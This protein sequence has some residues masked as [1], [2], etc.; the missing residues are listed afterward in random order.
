VLTAS[1]FDLDRQSIDMRGPSTLNLVNGVLPVGTTISTVG[2]SGDVALNINGRGLN[3]GLIKDESENLNISVGPSSTFD[4]YGTLDAGSS[5]FP[6]FLRLNSDAAD[7]VTNYGALLAEGVGNSPGGSF[8][9]AGGLFDNINGT[10]FASGG[11]ININSSIAFS[12]SGGIAAYNA[13]NG[14]GALDQFRGV[15]NITF[16]QS[17][18]PGSFV[19]SGTLSVGQAALLDIADAKF[20]SADSGTLVNSGLI[21]S[22]G[23]L[24]LDT[25]VQQFDSGQIGASAGG[26]IVVTRGVDGGIVQL[27]RDV[28]IRRNS[29]HA[30]LHRPA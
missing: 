1:N 21:T 12:N 8:F 2:E 4:N 16:G 13:P 9:V 24:I 28:G 14:R 5:A 29:A 18:S 6:T 23:N 3:G 26:T 25:P 17:Q 27:D 10:V 19:N 22:G 11:T 7:R 20:I 30:Q 15:I